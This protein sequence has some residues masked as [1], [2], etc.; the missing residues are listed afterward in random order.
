MININRCCKA[1]TLSLRRM[2]LYVHATL[3]VRSQRDF[4]MIVGEGS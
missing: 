3:I 4:C 1:N 2:Y